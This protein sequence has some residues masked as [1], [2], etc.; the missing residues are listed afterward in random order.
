MSTVEFL[1]KVNRQVYLAIGAQR[2]EEICMVVRNLGANPMYL[3]R[4]H[5]QLLL[6]ERHAF[7]LMVLLR[8]PPPPC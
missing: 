3:H 2:I 5:M 6:G 1:F 8:P 7:P 4:I